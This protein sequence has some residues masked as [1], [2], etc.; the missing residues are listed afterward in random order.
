VCKIQ[1]KLF[2]PTLSTFNAI[3]T[4]EQ[5]IE[6]LDLML[7]QHDTKQLKIVIEAQLGDIRT[8]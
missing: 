4:T 3:R 7:P 8:D 6:R 2:E 1:Q 5:V